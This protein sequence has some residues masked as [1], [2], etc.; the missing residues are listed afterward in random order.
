[1]QD[2]PTEPN[3]RVQRNSNQGQRGPWLRCVTLDVALR[4]VHRPEFRATDQ[5]PMGRT[6]SCHMVCS[7][8]EASSC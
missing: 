3:A 2:P 1:M 4:Q 5:S 7:G 8:L 6:H